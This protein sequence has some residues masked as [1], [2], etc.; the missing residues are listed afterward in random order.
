MLGL[1]FSHRVRSANAWSVLT[2]R[3]ERER[4]RERGARGAVIEINNVH[5]GVRGYAH[6]D[7]VWRRLV[8]M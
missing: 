6:V 3:R 5:A 2:G 7:C 8:G 4:E 1:N